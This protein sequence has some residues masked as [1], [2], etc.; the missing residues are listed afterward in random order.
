M[1]DNNKKRLLCLLALCSI[2]FGWLILSSGMSGSVAQQ[3]G[4]AI[5]EQRDFV[6]SD[7]CVTCHSAAG[8]QWA[9]TAHSVA[10]NSDINGQWGEAAGC[11]SCHGPGSEHIENPAVTDSILRFTFDSPTPVVAQNQV[12]LGCHQGGERIHWFGSVHD[13]N[14]IACAD[15]HN[16]MAE[17]SSSGLLA[18]QGVNETCFACHQTQRAEFNRRSHMP[19]TEGNIN[20]TDCHAPH[21]SVTSPL[22]QTTS[23]N[24]TCYQCHAEKRGPFLFEHAP[25]RESCTNCHTPHGSNHESLL[26]TARPLLCQQCHTMT[27]HVNDLMTR[28]NLAGGPRPDSRLIGR[29]CQNCHVQIHGSNH[30]SG[31]DFHR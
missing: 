25:V 20:C 13:R 6:G 28:G 9:H 23:I 14:D 16:P 27:G 21:G 10:F 30:P 26:L 12:C 15:C 22:L 1:P 18:R 3:S 2:P 5:F 31:A 19:L 7:T 8:T 11:E 17:F 29:S 4:L 24:E